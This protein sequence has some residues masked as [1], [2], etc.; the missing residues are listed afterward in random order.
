MRVS[1]LWR[2]LQMIKRAA[3]FLTGGVDACKP[4]SCA[5]PCYVC[6]THLDDEAIEGLF[7]VISGDP[8]YVLQ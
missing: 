2:H 8:L 4:G 7:E 5:V 6:P 1:R 3:V